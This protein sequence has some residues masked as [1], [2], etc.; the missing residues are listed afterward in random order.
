V[1]S[2]APDAAAA[3]S[4]AAITANLS[5]GMVHPH[6]LVLQKMLNEKGFTIAADGPGSPGQETEK[7]GF[8]TRDAVRKFQCAEMKICDGDEY[9]TGYGFVGSRTRAALLD[10]VP[11]VA[12]EAPHSQPLV[13]GYT[14]EQEAEIARLK[15]QIAELTKVLAELLEKQRS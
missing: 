1:D 2:A 4:G 7:F 6:V 9:T 10:A 13:S 12:D 8:L 3:A 11:R 15:A 5:F 14:T